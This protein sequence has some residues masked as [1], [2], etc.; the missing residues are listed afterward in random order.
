MDGFVTFE[1]SLELRQVGGARTIVGA[2]PYSKLGTISDRGSLRKERLGPRAFQHA[3]ETEPERRIDFLV[4]HDFGKPIAS[5]QSGTLQIADSA[6]AVTFTATLPDNP[7]SWVVDVEKA[8]DA[9]IMTGLSPGF[10]LPPRTV[11][12][13]AE[14]SCP[15]LGIPAY[16]YGKL[17]MRF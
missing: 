9:G 14:D 17:T 15:N 16:R 1:G 3:I 6:E 5:R 13:D 7:P 2:F 4:G 12:P 8:I 11:V 10:R